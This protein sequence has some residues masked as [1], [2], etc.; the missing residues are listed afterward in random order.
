VA[1]PST[2]WAEVIGADE[3][4]RHRAFAE[5]LVA[6]QASVDRK[7]DPGRALHRKQVLGLVAELEVAPDLP[8]HAAQGLFAQPRTYRGF[9]RLSN[10][11]HTARPDALP[12]IRGL[13]LSLRD[14][15]GAGALGGRTD[16]QDFVLINRP[17]F[18][19]ADSQ[20]FTAIVPA[21]AE[22][23]AAFLKALVGIFGPL[24]APL[25]GARLAKDLLRPFTGFATEP[26]F[27]AAPIQW[28]PY[29]A[30]VRLIPNQGGPGFTAG[31]DFAG[32]MARRLAQGPVT[33]DMHAQFFVSEPDTPIEDGMR[34]WSEE[35]SEPVRVGRVTLPAQEPSSEEGLAVGEQV[36]HDRFDPWSALVEH[37][38][39]GEIMRARKAAY[40]PSAKHRG[41]ART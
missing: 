7:E 31:L 38:P 29:A 35:I 28:G 12:D 39:L 36:E 33:Y 10:G 21:L 3:A 18:G 23:N 30:K 24:K 1:A 25:E 16:R 13:A 41:A 37:R 11:S 4:E 32:D 40:F 2:Q 34:D 14:V 17:A 15:D 19:F 22:G 6:I 9:A 27:S 8:A 5:Q 26:F 20:Q